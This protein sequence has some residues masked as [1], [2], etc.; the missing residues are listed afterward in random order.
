MPRWRSQIQKAMDQHSCD[1]PEELS[2]I[3]AAQK[4]VGAFLRNEEKCWYSPGGGNQGEWGPLWSFLTTQRTLNAN[5]PILVRLPLPIESILLFTFH[6]SSPFYLGQ[7]LPVDT[8]LQR[9]TGKFCLLANNLEAEDCFFK[10][11][12]AGSTAEAP[13]TA[14]WFLNRSGAVLNGG[15]GGGYLY[16]GNNKALKAYIT[17]TTEHPERY[18]KAATP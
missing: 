9:L 7:P 10:L 1:K 17:S 16:H 14:L 2:P 11:E 5:A 12:L 8:L 15:P 4:V 18:V 3:Q 6:V 13:L